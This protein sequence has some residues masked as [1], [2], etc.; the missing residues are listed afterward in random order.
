[1]LMLWEIRRRER[2]IQESKPGAGSRPRR[3]NHNGHARDTNNTLQNID[4]QRASRT[5]H[6]ILSVTL[7]QEDEMRKRL[8]DKARSCAL[9]KPHK[10]KWANRW[11]PKEL[12]LIARSEKEIKSQEG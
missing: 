9:C 6:R 2:D 10:K 11:K 8:K 1:M 7:V 3:A 5:V 4:E 12:D